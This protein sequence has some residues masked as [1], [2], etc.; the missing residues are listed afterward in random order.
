[1]ILTNFCTFVEKKEVITMSI[2]R[3][4]HELD[5]RTIAQRIATPHD[6]AR[7]QYYLKA[8]TVKSFD[9]F[10]HAIS[11]YYSYHFSKCVSPGGRLSPAEASSRAKE[12]LERQY[13]RQS[14]DIVSAYNDSHD[15]TNGG[16][17][18][19]LDIIADGLK[20][21]S[22]ER[23]IRDVFDRHV[24]PNSWEQKVKI[25]RE[26]I[27]QSGS[28]LSSTIRQDQPERYAQNFQELIRS[29]ISALQQ[30]SSL[31]RRL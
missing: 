15:G 22:I 18:T 8:N 27:E 29:Y 30:T 4:L 3:I 24:A 9:E 28:Y 20:A 7:M 11:D 16:L 17:R 1:M 12:M 2:A 6:E 31:F 26:F 13:R 14:G 21:E 10:N 19:V 25:I 5:E 23:Y